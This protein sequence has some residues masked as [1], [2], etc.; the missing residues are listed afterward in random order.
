MSLFPNLL[1]LQLAVVCAVTEVP[2][3]I[4]SDQNSTEGKIL[5]EDNL[6]KP[7]KG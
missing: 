2:E 1:P 4:Q 5:S 6:F 3:Y 7:Q